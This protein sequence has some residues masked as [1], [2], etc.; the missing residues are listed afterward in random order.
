M[1]VLKLLNVNLMVKIVGDFTFHLV[2]LLIK[3]TKQKA[4]AEPQN[5]D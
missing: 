4:L 5:S 2:I 1:F 3:K